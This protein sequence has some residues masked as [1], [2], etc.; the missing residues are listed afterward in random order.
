MIRRTLILASAIALT[1][2]IAA[3]AVTRAIAGA[4]YDA[5]RHAIYTQESQP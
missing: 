3:P 4:A 1:A 5:H 2:L